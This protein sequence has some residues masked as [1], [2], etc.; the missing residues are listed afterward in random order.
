VAQPYLCKIQ[1]NGDSAYFAA[2]LPVE[3]WIA[4]FPL[5]WRMPPNRVSAAIRH[6]ELIGNWLDKLT[7][8]LPNREYRNLA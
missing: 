2:F 6:D 3:P 7:A 4:E 8:A 1:V 5:I